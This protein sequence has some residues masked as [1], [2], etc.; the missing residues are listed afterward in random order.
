VRKDEKGRESARKRELVLLQAAARWRHRGG[1]ARLGQGHQHAGVGDVDADLAVV[2]AQQVGDALVDADA[3]QLLPGLTG[4]RFVVEGNR[5][6]PH[7]LP[8][9]QLL[10]GLGQQARI[11]TRP[12]N[13]ILPPNPPP[14]DLSSP[15]RE[16][17]RPGCFP[18][19]WQ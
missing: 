9:G 5:A 16:L 7:R 11:G 17:L 13:Y 14:A 10:L 6:K 8:F 1:H 3:D 4:Q 12:P 2:F 18:L 15:R 19:P